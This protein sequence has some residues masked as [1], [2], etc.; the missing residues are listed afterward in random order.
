MGAETLQEAVEQAVLGGVTMVQLREKDAEAVAFYQLAVEVKKVTEGYGIPLIINDR[1]DIAMAVDA[2]GVHV[3]Q[4]D[5]PV[6]VARKILGK[7]K[8]LGV[9]VS[10]LE[11]AVKAEAD[12]ADYLGVGAMLPTKTKEDAAVVSLDELRRIRKAVHIPVVAIGGIRKENA[13]LFWNCGVDGLAVVSAVI[14][15]KDIR[16]AALELKQTALFGREDQ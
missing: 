9:S 1:I 8:L 16:Q 7:D 4:T 11:E 13:A 15:Q 6:N 3:G 2:A 5:L 12:G 14:A 10:S